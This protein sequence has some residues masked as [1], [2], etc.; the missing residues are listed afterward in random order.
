MDR[1]FVRE[2]IK[3]GKCESNRYIPVSVMS[4]VLIELV[5]IPRGKSKF[6]YDISE[7]II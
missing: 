1:F 7:K 6:I 3:C 5:S 4:H 2:E